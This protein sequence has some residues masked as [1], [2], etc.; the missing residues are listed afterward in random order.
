MHNKDDMYIKTIEGSTYKLH[1]DFEDEVQ[2]RM[3]FSVGTKCPAFKDITSHL[4]PGE[5][6]NLEDS[7]A[8]LITVTRDHDFG[9]MPCLQMR[10]YRLQS[11]R[12]VVID[13]DKKKA[14]RLRAYVGNVVGFGLTPP[15]ETKAGDCGSVLLICDPKRP[16]KVVGLHAA[17][18][19]KTGYARTLT[20]EMFIDKAEPCCA[21]AF[22]TAMKEF[23]PFPHEVDHRGNPV[24]A[25][26]VI[27]PFKPEKTKLYSSP[28]AYGDC[29]YEPAVLSSKD[30]RAPDIENM[31]YQEAMKW[32]QPKHE[33]SEEKKQKLKAMAYE[34]GDYYGQKALQSGMHTTKLTK[35]EALNSVSGFT[36]SQPI[37][38]STSPGY[39]WRTDVSKGKSSYV[40]I[41][42]DGSRFFLKNKE[43][44]KLHNAI[45]ALINNAK[46]GQRGDVAFTVCLKDEL[47][48]K[49]KLKTKTRTIAAAPLHY[50]IAMRQYFHTIY[51][52]VCELWYKMP[53]QVG[54]SA[55][56]LDW[57]TLFSRL[58]SMSSEGW[59]LD[60][61]D[62]DF[63]IPLGYVEAMPEFYNAFA[64]LTDPDWTEEDDTTRAGLHK[65][66]E[67]F[68]FIVGALLYLSKGGVA[69]GHPGTAVENSII[70]LLML[71]DAWCE[72]CPDETM[73]NFETFMEYVMLVIYGDDV[74]ATVHRAAPWFSLTN[75]VA[76]FK[77]MNMV[78]THADKTSEIRDFY[79][80]ENGPFL[81][82]T[83]RMLNGYYIG[84]L[85][86][87][88]LIKPL[89]FAMGRPG[90]YW[91]KA[92]N[93]L[94]PQLKN[95]A[96][97]AR[98]ALDEM[99]LHGKE[100]YEDLRR[101]CI[102]V[103]SEYGIEE[104][105]PPYEIAFRDF[106]GVVDTQN[107]GIMYNDFPVS[108]SLVAE[109]Q[110]E[111]GWITYGN[112]R[113]VNFGPS[114]T[115]GRENSK[116]PERPIP[117]CLTTV[118]KKVN[119]VVK[120][121]Y[122]SVL[123]NVY[124]PGG[125]IPFHKDNEP[126]LDLNEGVACVTIIGDGMMTW[127]REGHAPIQLQ[128]RPEFIYVMRGELV[129]DWSHSRSQHTRYTMS[130]TFRKIRT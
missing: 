72:I 92:K 123:V 30:P 48:K 101:H 46:K 13:Q 69:S 78:V 89:N 80:I 2:D 22:P 127:K 24:E 122:N 108:K 83:F 36:H 81:S 1:V 91:F 116:F 118:L 129:T 59:S 52:A 23:V 55:N 121:D 82:R 100:K 110:K 32:V 73:R 56:S 68:Y 103:C 31:L 15:I 104:Y 26:C 63:N 17:A 77:K 88:R 28:F 98:S 125:S 43:V 58:I 79:P 112:R 57:H 66:L 86:M 128:C 111:R 20:R 53:V 47:L 50:T 42:D 120:A 40:E 6:S 113:S 3:N 115:Y 105:Y 126:E 12:Q 10:Y 74:K 27:P 35:R 19:N 51:A 61:K 75:I 90:H 64:R 70:S 93:E 21:M 60:H 14:C 85:E 117:S 95:C 39:P 34:I 119:E 107:P 109:L 11:Q 16:A 29:E 37:V 106:F 65:N 96:A 49:E 9:A 18:N 7:L 4:I 71:Y 130:L 67:R 97:A 38:I 33:F 41:A 54:I 76:F 102:Q 124:E 62:F 84:P 94:C 8:V 114:Y 87:H 99:F 45:D 5:S 44:K 25:K